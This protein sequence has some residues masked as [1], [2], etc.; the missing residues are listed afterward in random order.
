MF[1]FFSDEIRYLEEELEKVGKRLQQT[2]AEKS[3]LEEFATTLEDNE[4]NLRKNNGALKS[5]VQ[6][7]QKDVETKDQLVCQHAKWPENFF[8]FSKFSFSALGEL[9]CRIV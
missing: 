8:Y 6:D 3:Q 9:G 1:T 2:E 4:I 7:L 5:Q